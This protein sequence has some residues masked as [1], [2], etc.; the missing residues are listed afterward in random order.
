MQSELAPRMVAVVGAEDGV[1][2]STLISTLAVLLSKAGRS[3][4]LAVGR[5]L[6]V[7]GDLDTLLGIETRDSL[8]QFPSDY[9]LGADGLKSDA[10]SSSNVSIAE[11]KDDMSAIVLVDVLKKLQKS[12]NQGYVLLDIGVSDVILTQI[13]LE[14]CDIAIG[15]ALGESTSLHALERLLEQTQTREGH[16]LAIAN[17][18]SSMLS[19]SE[20][21]E[22]G[23]C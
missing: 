4:V 11:L 13:V 18:A 14:I 12:V 16:L 3:S 15:V 21:A 2:E 20:L 10:S 9:M 8:L 19:E 23:K 7:Y 17:R 22:I 6:R 5:D 1:G